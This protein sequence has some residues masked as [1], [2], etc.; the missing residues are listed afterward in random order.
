VRLD[1][2]PADVAH[3]AL[4]AAA[5]AALDA[6]LAHGRRPLLHAGLVTPAAPRPVG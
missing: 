3:P 6:L 2:H 5:V 4:L 1:L